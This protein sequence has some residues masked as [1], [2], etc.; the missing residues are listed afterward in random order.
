MSQRT[1]TTIGAVVAT[2]LAIAAIAIALLARPATAQTTGVTGMRQITVVGHGEAKGRP[3]M[4]TVQIGVRS[5]AATAQEA[6]AQNSQ[7]ARA[8]QDKLKEL[9]IDEK[10]IQ[11]S[12]F[13]IYPMYDNEGRNV[14]GYSVENTV[15]VTIR[16][17]DQTSDL[18]DQV[19]QAGANNI[20]GISFGVADTQELLGQARDQAVQN[21]RVRA[22]QLAK[23]AGA[24]VGEVLVITESIG[25]A[26]PIP[27]MRAE[28]DMAAGS[29]APP[30][31]AG[32]QTYSA[33]VQ[34]T[35]A[36]R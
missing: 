17:L 31:A 28:A 32:E 7:Q 10:D 16:N 9:G 11:T 27:L 24:S 36:L 1:L 30:I 13:S 33:D 23:A 19:V 8:I 20:Y 26:P 5:Q 35:F 12:N 18:L 2:L 4:A 15:S 29:A 21:A 3:D 6:L 25:S 22:E 34:I 14:T